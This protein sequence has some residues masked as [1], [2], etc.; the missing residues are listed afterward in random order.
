MLAEIPLE[1]FRDG[2]RWLRAHPAVDGGRIAAVAISKGAEGLLAAP[3]TCPS[4]T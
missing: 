2:I 4:W 1:R 3:R